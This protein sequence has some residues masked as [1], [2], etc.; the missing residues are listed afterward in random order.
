MPRAPQSIRRHR[1]KLRNA[2]GLAPAQLDTPYR[3]GGWT[4]RRVVH[5]LTDA[6]MN[7]YVRTKLA[8]T[9]DQP[10]VKPYDEALWAES[11]EAR[12][13]PI[14]PSLLLLG[15][16]YQRCTALFRSLDGGSM[17]PSSPPRSSVV[18]ITC[19]HPVHQ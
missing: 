10:L 2:A 9:E 17:E 8:L 12:T 7:W 3:R 1:A 15:A 19:R 16:L 14:E 5:H 18:Q 4:V 6:Q 11:I 13:G